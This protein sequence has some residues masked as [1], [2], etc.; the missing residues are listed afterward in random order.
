MVA[1]ELKR[2]GIQA[3]PAGILTAGFRAGAPGRVKVLVHESDLEKAK[4]LLDEY[5]H[6]RILKD[7]ALLI[8]LAPLGLIL[9]GIV[10]FEVAMGVTISTLPR[11]R[12][13]QKWTPQEQRR[14]LRV[15][16]TIFSI[17][18]SAALLVLA[19]VMLPVWLAVIADVIVIAIFVG[20]VRWWLHGVK[21]RNLIMA[22]HCEHCFY[23]LRATFEH[24]SDHCP[25][26][27][28]ALH[29]HPVHNAV[30]VER[31][32]GWSGNTVEQQDVSKGVD[33]TVGE[34]IHSDAGHVTVHAV[35]ARQNVG[36]KIHFSIPD[37]AVIQPDFIAVGRGQRAAAMVNGGYFDASFQPVGLVVNEGQA[38]S[39]MSQQTALSGVIAVFEGGELFLIP[40]SQYLPDSGIHSAIQ[41]GPFIIDA[42][43]KMGIRSDDLKKARRTAIG[44]TVSGEIVFITTTPCTLYQLA[45]ILIN[46][47]D[48]VGVARFDRVLNLDGG[49]ST[50]LY[51]HGLEEHHVAPET[52][53][54]NR[55]LMLKR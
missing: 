13:Q 1:D 40:R 36:F 20:C 33:L 25:E 16:F 18:P 26:C 48:A 12:F 35:T 32:S 23:D 46:H 52:E 4:A 37:P 11:S 2:E 30:P 55:V 3:E 41:A 10:T 7:P 8:T 39:E 17:W 9:L 27:G 19:H 47:H 34:F 42:G 50:G 14:V 24:G 53:V 5:T 21:Q 43:G 15:F 38:V 6:S 45:D 29:D 51:L 31:F 44:Q 22:G 54:P 28:A 49:P